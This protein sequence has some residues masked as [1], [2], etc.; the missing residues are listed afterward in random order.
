MKRVSR[1]LNDFNRKK[2]CLQSVLQTFGRW[3][4]EEIGISSKKV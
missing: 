1:D 3:K 4:S 2:L